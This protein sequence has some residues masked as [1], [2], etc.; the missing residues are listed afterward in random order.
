[1]VYLYCTYILSYSLRETYMIDS[2]MCIYESDDCIQSRIESFLWTTFLLIFSICK[3][4]TVSYVLCV[5]FLW[6]VKS[7]LIVVVA[8]TNSLYI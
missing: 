3:T 6:T 7:M 2:A 8:I 4:S 1:M 5:L